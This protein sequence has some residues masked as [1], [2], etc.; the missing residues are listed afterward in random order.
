MVRDVYSRIQIQKLYK[1]LPTF[2]KQI[3]CYAIILSISFPVKNKK[4]NKIFMK[5]KRVGLK[6]KQ[7]MKIGNELV[8]IR[9]LLM[10]LHKNFR[11]KS[12]L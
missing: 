11:Q 3:A 10:W 8:S 9:V 6:L 2:S 7:P 4:I 1:Y 5:T 12:L